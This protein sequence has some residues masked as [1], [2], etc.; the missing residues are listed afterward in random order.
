METEKSSPSALPSPD[1]ETVGLPDSSPCSKQCQQDLL[2]WDHPMPGRAIPVVRPSV[3]ATLLD[4][5]NLILSSS[6]CAE[7][8]TITV[9]CWWPQSPRFPLFL[10]LGEQVQHH[11]PCSPS[12]DPSIPAP[13]NTGE[14]KATHSKN[15]IFPST[16]TSC[17]LTLELGMAW[18]PPHWGPGLAELGFPG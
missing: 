14:E 9:W 6:A 13:C 4:L 18:P 11:P 3:C 15:H 8:N 10:S 17:S 5:R 12:G 1:P 7:S 2:L 16:A